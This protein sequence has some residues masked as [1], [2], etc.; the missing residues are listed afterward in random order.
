MKPVDIN[1]DLGE[2][3]NLEDCQNDALLMP[4]ISRC[5]IACGGHAGNTLTIRQTLES[6]KLHQIIAGA[7]PGYADPDNF[8]R[9]S[10]NQDVSVTL[11]DVLTQITL[12]T[13]HAE[14]IGVPIQHIK[15]HGALYNDAEKSPH[16]AKALCQLF[17]QHFPNLSIVGLAS[18]AMENAAKLHNLHFIREGFMDRAYMPDGHLAPRA[19]PGSVYTAPEQC[20]QQV[21]TILQ[22]RP[23]KSLESSEHKVKDVLVEVD[24]FCLHG[25]GERALLV[26]KMLSEQLQ[27]NGYSIT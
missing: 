16:L 18:G 15:L 11:A 12:L 6:A 14:D 21:L 17:S 2:G 22:G 26:A 13:S 10:L 7:H 8:G 1:C 25:D 27:S 3:A 20:I 23:I 24:T 4:Y 9:V 19:L 5:N